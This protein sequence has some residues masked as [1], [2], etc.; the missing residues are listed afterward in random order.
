MPCGL[1]QLSNAA[2]NIRFKARGARIV[3]GEC[4]PFCHYHFRKPYLSQ[5]RIK[6]SDAKVGQV[7]QQYVVAIGSSCNDLGATQPYHVRLDSID[8]LLKTR[9]FPDQ[10]CRSAAAAQEDAGSRKLLLEMVVCFQHQIRR[11]C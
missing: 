11:V 1:D 8:H 2:L 4:M 5:N 9:L 10:V 3:D 6:G 7:V